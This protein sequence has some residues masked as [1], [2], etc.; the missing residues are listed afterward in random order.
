MDRDD[1]EYFEELYAGDMWIKRKGRRGQGFP[2][3]TKDVDATLNDRPHYTDT[4]FN[5]P[6]TIFCSEPNT[7][8]RDS[9]GYVSAPGLH[10]VYDD[11]VEGWD[12][13][14]AKKAAL[15]ASDSGARPRTARWYEVYLGHFF[16]KD[17]KELKL[18]HIL[19]GVNLSSGYPYCVFGYRAKE[20]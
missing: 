2:T 18:V 1:F 5:K 9:G 4:R 12:Y 7:L 19:A 17:L 11:R 6:Q 16:R 15:V 3:G 8:R 20:R 10:Y 14:R 13:K